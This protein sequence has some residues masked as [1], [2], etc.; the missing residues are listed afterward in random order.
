ML[1]N[2]TSNDLYSIQILIK[3]GVTVPFNTY[4]DTWGIPHLK[5]DTEIELAFAQGYNAALDRGWQIEVERQR[6]KGT[7]ASFLGREHLE[8]DKF[9]RRTKIDETARICYQNLNFETRHWILSFV[10][11]INAAVGKCDASA[12]DEH[13]ISAQPW[14]PWTP[15]SVWLSTHILMG[16]FA[17]KLWK[18]E[19]IKRL[20]EE[21]LNC[22]S[23]ENFTSANSNG[24]Y[25]PGNQTESGFPLQAGD[26]HRVV[27]LPSCYQQVRLSC[28][29]Y[30]VVGF[31]V[32][33]IPGIAHFGHTGRVA[34]SITNAMANYQDL[35]FE[36]ITCTE[37]VYTCEGP[38]GTE[39]VQEIIEIIEIRNEESVEIRVLETNRGPVIVDAEGDNLAISIRLPTREFFVSG[40]DSLQGLLRAK[41]VSDVEQ[42]FESW[43]EPV[44]VLQA[45][46]KEGGH[47]HKVVGLVPN[48]A[49]ENFNR[50][51]PAWDA[52]FEWSGTIKGD[53]CHNKNSVAVMANQRGLAANM[54]TD[55]SPPHRANRINEMI[56]SQDKWSAKEMQSIHTDC[57]LSTAHI[58][59]NALKDEKALPEA[60]AL[61]VERLNNWDFHMTAESVESAVFSKLRALIVNK[62]YDASELESL[63]LILNENKYPSLFSPWLCLKSRIAFALESILVNGIPSINTKGIVRESLIEL[64]KREDLDTPWGDLHTITPWTT[65]SGDDIKIWSG[66]GGDHD[67]VLS[68]YSLPGITHS[69]W[70]APVA[71]YVWDIA[72]VDQS[73]WISQFG[74]SGDPDNQHFSDQFEYWRRGELIPIVTDWDE[75][76]L[77]E[78]FVFEQRK[79]TEFQHTIEGVGS[80]S[81]NDLD[82]ENDIELI[83]SWVTQERAKYW[84]MTEY[85]KKDVALVYEYI[86]A[87]SH[88]N[89][90]MMRL[91]GV[92]VCFFQLYDPRHEEVGSKYEVLEG[93]IGLHVFVAYTDNP[94]KGFSGKTFDVLKEF[95]FS[96]QENKRIIGEPDIRNEKIQKRFLQFG[97]SLGGIVEL[98]GKQ[99]Q[100]SF[101]EKPE[102]EAII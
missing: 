48:R 12:F 56:A 31:A 41:T 52:R 3:R 49:E 57:Y 2:E 8:W 17:S 87:E 79:P 89:T 4:R 90:Y 92:P 96:N 38:N 24:W 54:G 98:T 42:A 43:V 62:I 53:V 40:F 69:C 85:E 47:C 39:D 94:I 51:V 84:G 13:G 64:S 14:E 34:W 67:C 33:G 30:D 65:L 86:D 81:I 75:L 102:D 80:V 20:G 28:D 19:V 26:P 6:V 61:L 22:F 78:T 11:G 37:G 97:F 21:Y 29:E 9:A 82:I 88:H 32:P 46:D 27:E 45:S 44:N 93:D 77:E 16:G 50:V 10:K 18:E 76:T 58:I 7:S 74:A 60:A 70:R 83:H 55:F 35:Y 63:A 23:S 15:I 59:V 1:V 36:K 101:F 66:I 71:R 100:L 99:A 91:D 68:S 72:G 25:I 73:F 5:A 95:I